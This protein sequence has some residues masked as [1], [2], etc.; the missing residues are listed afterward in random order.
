MKLYE[1]SAAYDQVRAMLA[2]PD[3]D[4]QTISDTLESIQGEAEDKLLA[5]GRLI[6]EMEAEA[7]AIAAEARRLTLRAAAAQARVGGLKEYARTHMERVGLDRVKDP[8]ITLRLQNSPPRVN[9]TNEAVIPSDFKRAALRLPL[10]DVPEDLRR[11]ATVEVDKHAVMQA[12]KAGGEVPGAE[13]VQD[14]HL[15]IA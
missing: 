8:V 2:D 7:D 12:I 14:R 4:P 13:V 3:V 6:R 10:N 5:V 1:L 11:L 15:R 9:V